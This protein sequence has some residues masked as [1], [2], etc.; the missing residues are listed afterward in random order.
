MDLAEAL[1]DGLS[2]IKMQV[3]SALSSCPFS[4]QALLPPQHLHLCL[5]F[6]HPRVLPVSI[7]TQT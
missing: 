3:L 4:V 7:A 2:E 5:Q 6:L 1:K